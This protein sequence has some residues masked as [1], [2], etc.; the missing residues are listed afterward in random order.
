MVSAVDR[1]SCS[2]RVE[3]RP[4]SAVRHRCLCLSSVSCSVLTL[5]YIVCDLLIGWIM[6]PKLLL[7]GL[8][9]FVTA[10]NHMDMAQHRYIL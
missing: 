9:K 3:L 8:R 4:S 5:V 10:L 7:L 1:F 6:V 2:A